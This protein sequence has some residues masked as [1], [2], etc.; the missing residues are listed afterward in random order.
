MLNTEELI[1]R[2]DEQHTEI[3]GLH[4][5]TD[6]KVDKTEKSVGEIAGRM[7][8]VEQTIAQ[9]RSNGGPGA[10]D[11]LGGIIIKSEGYKQ[12]TAAG[13]KGTYRVP[14]DTK[15]ITT[16]ASSGGALTPP[17][18]QREPVMIPRTRLTVRNLLAP[19]QTN[20]NLVKFTRQIT[21]T[22]AA[23]V[24][25]EGAQKPESNIIF[26]LVD[27]PVR[28]IATWIPTSRQIMDDAPLL[29]STLDSEL[30][31]M[32][33]LVEEEEILFGDGTGE[34]L[35]GLS[36]QV[37]PFN[38]PFVVTAQT[39]LDIILV[40]IAQAQQSKVMDGCHRQRSRLEK[41]AGP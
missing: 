14:L 3:K 19:G 1:R 38:A 13:C 9:R 6:K 34:H 12:F 25:T 10:P 35:S 31:Y 2:L 4:T 21:R 27:A 7:T 11:T 28:T 24:V 17:D 37:T 16:L 30:R 8:E 23:S 26:E 22:N 33:G 5:N 36:S 29:Q 18:F 40:A 41:D 39:N 20:S 15:A 32:I